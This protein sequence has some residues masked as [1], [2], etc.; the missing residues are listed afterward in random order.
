MN[1]NPWAFTKAQDVRWIDVWALGPFMVWYGLKARGVP[2]WARSA[3]VLSGVLTVVY[4]GAN[5]YARQRYDAAQE[6]LDPL[7]LV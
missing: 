6:T 1:D 5:Y 2:Q 3:M 4:N 7:P